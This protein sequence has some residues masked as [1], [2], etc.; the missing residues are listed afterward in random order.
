MKIRIYLS[1]YLVLCFFQMVVAQSDISFEHNGITRSY[2]LTIPDNVPSQAPL[3][4]VLHGYTSNN[5]I[6]QS[7]SGFDALAATE[8]FA[9]C[10][11]LGTN[12]AF[13]GNTHWNANLS[14]SETDDIG[15]LSEL[16]RHLQETYDLSADMTFA[17]GMSNG[18]F[19]S[20]TLACEASDVFSAIA[21]VTGTMS[22]YDWNNCNPE[23]V[24]PVMQISGTIDQ[25]VP[26]DG[27]ITESGG[28]GGAPDI[29]TVIDYWR[30]LNGLDVIAEEIV[31]ATNPTSI[32]YHSSMDPTANQVWQYVVEGMDH[33][34][35]GFWIDTGI[36]GATEIWRFF[37]RV[38]DNQLVNTEKQDID[39][40]NI[41]PNPAIDQLQIS[42]LTDE[43]KFSITDILGKVIKTG[44]LSQSKHAISIEG[45]VSGSYIL[46]IGSTSKWFIKQ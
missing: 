9:V 2:N 34:W 16:A 5:D 8:G 10:Y 33:T 40:F 3:V 42:G 15:F 11:P 31:D 46:T 38:V 17:C 32:T 41:F 22:G 12:D 36:D 23:R 26:M 6:I 18:G 13:V 44:T 20:Y 30:D 14:I 24:I 27:S 25:V 28:W 35:P 39:P 45:F 1:L 43:S 19:M 21:S 7:Y 37:S 4:F 29:Y